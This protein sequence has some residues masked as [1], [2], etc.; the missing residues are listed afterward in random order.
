ML[1]SEPGF[2]MR[3]RKMGSVPNS[4]TAGGDVMSSPKA[5]VVSMLDALPEDA[6]LEDIQYHLYVLEKVKRGLQRADTE[7]AI[8]HEKARSRLSKW[9]AA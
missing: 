4:F 1:R 3:M 9:L 7:G 5:D 6:S 2:Q 8:S